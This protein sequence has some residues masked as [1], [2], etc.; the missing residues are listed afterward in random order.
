MGKH[1]AFLAPCKQLHTIMRVMEGTL[2]Q[3][4]RA[5][6]IATYSEILL[7][8]PFALFLNDCSVPFQS[9]FDCP[10]QMASAS[11]FDF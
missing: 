1:D 8:E 4:C 10:C 11:H 3:D 9:R 5:F 6:G 7:N 2:R